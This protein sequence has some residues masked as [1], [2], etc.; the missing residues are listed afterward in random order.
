MAFIKR[1]TKKAISKQVN[2]LIRK[3]GTEIAV[4][5]VSNLVT[6]IASA[7]IA[8]EDDGEAPKRKRAK[9]KESTDKKKKTKKKERT[10]SNEQKQDGSD[11][12][13]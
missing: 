4:G 10:E 5:L 9:D 7:S 3:H 8:K 13:A 11:D 12:A 2:K 6:G 1:K